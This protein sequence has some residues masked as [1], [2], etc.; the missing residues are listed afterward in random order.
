MKYTD[1]DYEK[2]VRLAMNDNP[3]KPMIILSR[4]YNE[5]KDLYKVTVRDRYGHYVTI[6]LEGKFVRACTKACKKGTKAWT[7]KIELS[8]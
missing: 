8:E 2:G 4:K 1:E 5:D 6:R 7:D 3:K